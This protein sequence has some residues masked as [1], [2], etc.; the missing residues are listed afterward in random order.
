MLSNLLSYYHDFVGSETDRS[1]LNF[2]IDCRQIKSTG[3]I[4]LMPQY[5]LTLERI[6]QTRAQIGP[7]TMIFFGGGSTRPGEENSLHH[8]ATYQS[9]T[10]L[11]LQMAVI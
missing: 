9:Q 1:G 3:D 7:Q 2:Q 6:K 5:C 4:N 10:Q 8:I 11:R